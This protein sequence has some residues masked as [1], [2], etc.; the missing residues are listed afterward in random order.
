MGVVVDFVLFNSKNKFYDNMKI[1]LIFNKRKQ[2]KK[3]K[4]NN[5]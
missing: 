3:I 4:L 2:E 5:I 1:D